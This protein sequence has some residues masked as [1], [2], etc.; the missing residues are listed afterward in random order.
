MKF[1]A[2]FALLVASV[3]AGSVPEP[4]QAESEIALKQQRIVVN[5]IS[6]LI[7]DLILSIQDA[8]LDPMHIE[9]EKYEWA[10]P[11]PAILNANAIVE[12]VRSNGLSNIVI[13]RLSFATLTT[14]LNF[15]IEL[16]RVEFSVGGASA[17]VSTFGAKVEG[18]AHGRLAI[19]RIRIVGE[20]RVSLGIISGISIR[21]LRLDFTLGGIESDLNVVIQGHDI[22]EPLND[23]I[24]VRIPRALHSHRVSNSIFFKEMEKSEIA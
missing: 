10:L 7:E 24:G 15:D 16:P 14:R 8:G 13:N 9:Q 11:V 1:F 22:S 20:V 12:N 18:R 2:V 19:S 3:C 23:F 5:I 21:N 6:S 4:V 17:Q